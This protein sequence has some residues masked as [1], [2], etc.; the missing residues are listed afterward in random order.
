MS[1]E[2]MYGDLLKEFRESKII[3]MRG[4]DAD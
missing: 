2:E 4:I 3:H 1:G